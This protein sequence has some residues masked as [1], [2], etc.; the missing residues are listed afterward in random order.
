MIQFKLLLLFAIVCINQIVFADITVKRAEYVQFL[1]LTQGGWTTYLEMTCGS[2][3]MEDEIFNNKST[4]PY[5]SNGHFTKAEV[6]VIRFHL[7]SKNFYPKCRFTKIRENFKFEQFE[8]L[9]IVDLSDVELETL[10]MDALRNADSVKT[11]IAS[12]NRLTDIS[13]KLFP[14][15]V[16]IEELDLSG[17]SIQ[18]ID[19]SVM[20]SARLKILKISNNPISEFGSNC[21]PIP[22]LLTLD[23]SHNRLKTVHEDAFYGA[24]NLKQLDLSYNLLGSLKAQLFAR[25][26]NLE[27]VSLKHAEITSIPPGAFSNQP[28]LISLDLSENWLVHLDFSQIFPP[29]LL[30]IE[31][32]DLNQN[33]LTDLNGCRDS[34]VPNLKLMD[35]RSN[36][37]SCSYLLQLMTDV[38]WNVFYNPFNKNF[39]DESKPNIQGVSCKIQQ[40]DTKI[41][42]SAAFDHAIAIQQLIKELKYDV[43]FNK[44]SIITI[45]V[46]VILIFSVKSCLCKKR[47]L[48]FIRHRQNMDFPANIATHGQILPYCNTENRKEINRFLNGIEYEMKD[49][50]LEKACG[51]PIEVLETN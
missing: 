28:D 23:M 50:Y 11:L 34:V 48:N 8:N 36:D 42:E 41:V 19:P 38:S 9:E 21:F 4:I 33:L 49:D 31:T 26:T 30:R 27:V 47:R 3:S 15:T 18:R 46:C 24:I 5:N 14:N 13:P 25:L 35:I 43:T 6:N 16:Q 29:S 12:N 39:T 20:K 2:K 22:T 44:F 37:F 51:L 45:F 32:I 40:K 7:T 1:F 17:N 10:Q